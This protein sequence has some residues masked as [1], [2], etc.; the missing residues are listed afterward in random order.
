MHEVD[1]SVCEGLEDVPEL[2]RVHGEVEEGDHTGD[3]L[4][5]K[6]VVSAVNVAD[7]PISVVVTISA[8]AK[9]SFGPLGLSF[10]VVVV[11]TE[12]VHPH[13]SLAVVILLQLSPR[14]LL[15]LHSL[16]LAGYQSFHPS[17]L[18]PL[19]PFLFNLK[20][21]FILSLFSFAEA[22]FRVRLHER[23]GQVSF[24]SGG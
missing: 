23:K 5:V 19:S 15:L 24:R 18:S 16:P 10:P 4:A 9:G 17:L 11:V 21:Q 8:G 1:L 14:L 3:V 20:L 6:V 2:M 7:T 13:V 12:T 22:D